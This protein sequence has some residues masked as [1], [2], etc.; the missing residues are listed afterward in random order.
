MILQFVEGIHFRF[1]VKQFSPQ[2]ASIRARI[3]RRYWRDVC[4]GSP[5]LAAGLYQ[6]REARSLGSSIRKGIAEI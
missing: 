3:M 5:N 6:V 2:D 1:F 4:N